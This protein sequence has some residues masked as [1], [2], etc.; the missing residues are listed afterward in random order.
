MSSRGV[1]AAISGLPCLPHAVGWRWTVALAGFAAMNH[2]HILMASDASGACGVVSLGTVVE[3]PD[4]G[5][6]VGGAAAV[7]PPQAARARNDVTMQERSRLVM[8]WASY[9]IEP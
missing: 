6:V 8:S 4:G 7:S 9:R 1:Q 2:I 5:E 3:G